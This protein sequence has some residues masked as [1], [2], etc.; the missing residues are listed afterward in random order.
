MG[1]FV[2]R[3]RWLRRLATSALL[4]GSMGLA[5][6]GLGGCGPG[7]NPSVPEGGWVQVS[8]GARHTCAIQEDGGLWCWGANAYGQVGNGTTIDQQWPVQIPFAQ[9]V[10]QVVCGAEHT[11][12]LLEEGGLHCWGRNELG[13][14]GD[15]TQTDRSTPVGV[16]DIFG[17]IHV[18]ASDRHTCAVESGGQVWCWG[19][20]S[21]GQL[22]MGDAAG[23][24]LCE[25]EPPTACATT[26]QRVV[27]I[28]DAE[29]VVAGGEEQAGFGCALTTLN[30]V[31]CWGAN[32]ERQLGDG[33]LV[34]RNRPVEVSELVGVQALT[35]GAAHA[36]AVLADGTA[37]CWGRDFG[38]PFYIS[39]LA[40]VTTVTAGQDF[41]CALLGDGSLQCWGKNGDGQLGDGSTND[42]GIPRPVADLTDPGVIQ[43]SAGGTHTCAVGPDGQTWCW[44][45]NQQGQ[46]GGTSQLSSWV[47]VKVGI[48]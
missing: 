44:G 30:R 15:G 31:F 13:Q 37:Y 41:T 36:C 10:R 16:V 35:A 29:R 27:A 26:P 46:L 22:G 48:R 32:D 3:A 21:T 4:L 24:E 2:S 25:G 18:D 12:A 23:P 20:N 43:A 34:S 42:Q 8:A 1:P 7:E 38:D 28:G 5:S 6:A 39:V 19:A 47:P 45:S 40:D 11:C 33:T 17:L 9:P 14:L